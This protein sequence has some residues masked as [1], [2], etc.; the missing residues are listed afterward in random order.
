M[1]AAPRSKAGV[2]YALFGATLLLFSF[3]YN[4]LRGGTPALAPDSYEYAQVAR[5]LLT[6]RGLTTDAISVLELAEF[7]AGG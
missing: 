4:V 1:R 5:N 7:G 2:V 3:H 6:G